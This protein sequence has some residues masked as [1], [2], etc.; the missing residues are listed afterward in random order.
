MNKLAKQ[1]ALGT[2]SVIPR[3]SQAQLKKEEVLSR[4]QKMK[5]YGRGKL[6]TKRSSV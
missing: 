2:L 3:K 5:K 1:K 6:T 4:L